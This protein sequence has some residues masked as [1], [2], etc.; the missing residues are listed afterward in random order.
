MLLLGEVAKCKLDHSQC[1]YTS[2][3]RERKLKCCGGKNE[4]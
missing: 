2:G 1:V 3:K 4:I